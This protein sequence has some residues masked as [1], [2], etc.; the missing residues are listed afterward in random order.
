MEILDEEHEEERNGKKEHVTFAIFQKKITKE[1]TTQLE[2]NQ[3]IDEYTM[4][5]VLLGQLPNTG[6]VSKEI[7]N[8]PHI[9][10]KP[11]IQLF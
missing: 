1:S 6:W 7:P 3:V 8:N 11:Q 10:S 4:P 5:D 9:M 2:N